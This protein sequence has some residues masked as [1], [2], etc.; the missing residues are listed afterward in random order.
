M[1][2]KLCGA[3]LQV[4]VMVSAHFDRIQL[5]RK[6]TLG[7][8]L[9]GSCTFFT[10]FD[11]PTLSGRKLFSILFSCFQLVGSLARKSYSNGLLHVV[12][13]LPNPPVGPKRVTSHLPKAYSLQLPCISCKHYYQG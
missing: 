5:A 7:V 11:H 12:G 1:S 6:L 13:H 8:F 2:V 9:L 4:V 10:P 3:D